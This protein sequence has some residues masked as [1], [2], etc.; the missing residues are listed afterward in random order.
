MKA[1]HNASLALA[2]MEFAELLFLLVDNAK[3]QLNA[4][5]AFPAFMECVVLQF[6]LAESVSIRTNV[7]VITLVSMEFVELQF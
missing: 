4:L 6:N 7:S 3:V 5:L 2:F 1:Q